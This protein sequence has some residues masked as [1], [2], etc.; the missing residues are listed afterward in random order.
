MSRSTKVKVETTTVHFVRP[1]L[2]FNDNTFELAQH[3][4]DY[5]WFTLSVADADFPS[6]IVVDLAAA[7][8]G[9]SLDIPDDI[10]ADLN[11]QDIDDLLILG[12]VNVA[13]GFTVN[14]AGPLVVNLI[15]KT[16]AQV[17]QDTDLPTAAPLIGDN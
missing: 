12:I 4:A 2:G 17:V 16:I 6:F 3:D 14:L 1:L 8:T 9:L 13:D 11:A 10:A 15:A 5:P 7:F